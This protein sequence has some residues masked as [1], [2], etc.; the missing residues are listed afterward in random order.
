MDVMN[1]KPADRRIEIS[2][3]QLMS[4]GNWAEVFGD[5]S[6]GNTDK[7]TDE[8]PPGSG[9]D[10]TPPTRADVAEIIAGVNGERDEDSWV[11]VFRLKDGRY[12][13]ASGWCD[14]TGWD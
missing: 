14:Y 8:C 9:V 7:T 4:D 11:G 6:S 5:E 12:L 1:L 13:V 3:D 10:R 2:M